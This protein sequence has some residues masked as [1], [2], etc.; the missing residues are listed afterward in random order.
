[1]GKRSKFPRIVRDAYTTPLEAVLPLLPNLPRRFTFIEPCAHDGRLIDHLTK[2]GGTCIG[3]WD[4]ATRR[5]DIKKR[6]ALTLTRADVP[7]GTLIITNSPWER[8]VLHRMIAHFA[9]LAPSWLLIDANWLNTVQAIPFIDRLHAYQ[10]IG[11]VRW[12]EGTSMSGKDDAAWFLFGKSKPAPA[13][14]YSRIRQDD[15]HAEAMRRNVILICQGDK[16]FGRSPKQQN[17]LLRAA[18]RKR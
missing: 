12:I 6:D 13:K 16:G 8:A 2:A 15:L 1:M 11:R 17:T 4:I 7:N 14:L 3:A 5:S 9:S 18:A 10:P